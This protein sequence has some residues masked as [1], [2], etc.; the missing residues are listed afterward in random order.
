MN[1]AAAV[2]FGNL[3]DWRVDAD[4]ARSGVP[5]DLGQG[6]ALIVKRANLFDRAV[7]ALFTDVDVTS[8]P[9]IQGVYAHHLVV[10]WR[11]ILDQAG[12]DIPYTPAAC[13]AL[14]AHA[15]EVWEALQRFS[16]SRANYRME[17]SREDAETLKG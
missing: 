14:F 15:P 16:L 2:Q 6:R 11:G 5:F 12:H 4:K 8:E 13:L 10:G 1:D 3:D 17:K 9:A 7:A